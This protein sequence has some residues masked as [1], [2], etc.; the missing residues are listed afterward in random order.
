MNDWK[1]IL[2]TEKATLFEE[3][4]SIAV[5]DKETGDWIATLD[6]VTGEADPNMVADATEDWNERRALTAQLETRYHNIKLALHKIEQ[7]TYGVCE[8][9][10]EAIEN[11]RLGANPAARTC[12]IH[13]EHER[14]LPF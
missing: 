11:D 1:K 6:T 8:I 2:E 10:G 7:D 14:E 9:C 4:T 13:I 5:E 12:K 3:L